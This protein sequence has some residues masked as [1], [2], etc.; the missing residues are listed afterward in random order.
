MTVANTH[1]AIPL[2]ILVV[3]EER[4]AMNAMAETLQA[5]GYAPT[6]ADDFEHATALLRTGSFPLL[7]TAERLGAHDGLH[8]VLRAKA[9]RTAIGAV[10]STTR[11]DPALEA[12]A[13]MFGA[14]CVI[15]PWDHPADLIAAL[16]RLSGAPSA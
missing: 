2:Q 1:S 7:I 12:E 11:V 16:A 8:L 15:A 4:Q 13:G 14:L 10:V 9:S 6:L 3:D 5:A